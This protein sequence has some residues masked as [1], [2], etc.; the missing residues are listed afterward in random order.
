MS[1]PETDL[2]FHIVR[3]PTTLQTLSAQ[4]YGSTQS[5][6]A[7]EFRRINEPLTFAGHLLEGQFLYLPEGA[8]HRHE[9][10]IMETLVAVNKVIRQQMKFD[11]RRG[12]AE[13]HQTLNSAAASPGTLKAGLSVVGNTGSAL[14]ASLELNAKLMSNLLRDLESRYVQEIRL[15]GRLTPDFFAY[16]QSVLRRLD[17]RIGRTART[18]TLGT[19][20]DERARQSLRVNIK[21][22]ILRWQRGGTTDGLR[23]FRDHFNRLRSLST[24]A[25]YGGVFFIALDARLTADTIAKACKAE[26]DRGCDRVTAVETAGL[27]GRTAGG[28]AGGY[29]AYTGCSLALAPSTVGQVFCGADWW[30]AELELW[31]AP[32]G[33]DDQPNAAQR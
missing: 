21:S 11:E 20:Y 22:Q 4:L 27:A 10:E 23:A 8:C 1:R 17:S 5:T 14:T 29:L 18:I 2:F 25:K 24:Y 9:R 6:L 33:Q 30:Q 13:Q 3:H 15:H 32:G 31:P 28:I 19:P 12:L 26:D 16:R 7:K